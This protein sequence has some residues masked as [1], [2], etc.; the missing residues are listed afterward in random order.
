MSIFVQLTSFRIAVPFSL[1]IS[2]LIYTLIS[3]Y[4]FARRT[5]RG[6][7]FPPGPPTIPF[8]GNLH[9]IPLKKPFLK[10]EEWR[11]QYGDII[12]LKMGPKNLVVLSNPA[13]VRELFQR[14]GALYS[15]RPYMYIPQEHVMKPGDSHV[16]FMQDGPT[17]RRWKT[18][19]RGMTD[20]ISVA[21]LAPLQVALAEKLVWQ[22]AKEPTG[23]GKYSGEWSLSVPLLCVAGQTL[24]DYPHGFGEYY[25]EVQKQWSVTF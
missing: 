3:L 9:Q 8:I 1:F 23:W 13:H 14:R 11:H 15:G 21:R 25:L 17:L 5:R 10:F 2:S 16:L 7:S 18:A 4:L 6:P 20:Q 12:G 19:A 22:L 24:D